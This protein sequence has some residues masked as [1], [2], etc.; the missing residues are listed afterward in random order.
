MVSLHGK[1]S[2]LED[3]DGITIVG[4]SAFCTVLTKW[5]TYVSPSMLILDPLASRPCR[6]I[7]PTL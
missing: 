3:S 1:G 2:D 7:M 6:T 5:F 4:V